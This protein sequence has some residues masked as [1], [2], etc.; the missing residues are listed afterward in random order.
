MY[1]SWD[2]ALGVTGIPWFVPL[3]REDVQKCFLWSDHTDS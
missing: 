3:C 2:I 1:K